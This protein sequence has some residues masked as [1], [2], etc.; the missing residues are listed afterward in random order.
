MKIPLTIIFSAV[1]DEQQLDF[2]FIPEIVSEGLE[3]KVYESFR[4]KRLIAIAEPQK[5]IEAHM[6]EAKKI[7]MEWE[8]YKKEAQDEG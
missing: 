4:G 2:R 5:D 3:G 8:A 1:E 7:D 6:A